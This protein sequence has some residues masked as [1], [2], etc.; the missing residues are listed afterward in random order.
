MMLRAF[1]SLWPDYCDG[2]LSL[3]NVLCT[4][5]TVAL[6]HLME[7]DLEGYE[8]LA[9]EWHPMFAGYRQ[10]RQISV[11]LANTE[12]VFLD[13]EGGPVG[14]GCELNPDILGAFCK[15]CLSNCRFF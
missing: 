3:G 13:D 11:L 2:K 10:P 4:T 9:D 8:Y 14:C 12:G 6:A 5:K 7:Y 1:F 15:F